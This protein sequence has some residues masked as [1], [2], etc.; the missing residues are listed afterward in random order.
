MTDKLKDVVDAHEQ[1]VNLLELLQVLVSRKMVIIKICAVAIVASVVYSLLLPDIY[2]ATTKVLPPQKDSAGGLSALLSQGGVGSLVSG[3]IGGTSDLYV[4]ILKSRSVSS[5][6]TQ[7]LDLV[8]VYRAASVEEARRTAEGAITAQAGKDG[9]ITITADDTDPKLAAKLANAFADELGRATVR[10]NLSKAG[11]ERLFLEKRLELVKS[12][13][14]AAE[15]DLKAF[16]QKN[17]IMQVDAQVGA[18]LNAVSRLKEELSA[19]EVE[20]SILRNQQTDQSPNVKALNSAIARLK[21]QIHELTG[22][23]SGGEGIPSVGSI[24]GMG[25]EYSRKLRELKTQEAV[26]EQLTKQYE[27]AKLSEA[28]DSSSLQVLDEAVV[29][30]EKS[31]PKRSKLVIAA[32]V[33]AFIFSVVVVFALEYLSRTSIEDR[34][35]IESIKRDVFTLRRRDNQQCDQ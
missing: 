19:K 26:F 7:R 29:P 11:A 30:L 15:D 34:K 35:I 25:L 8:T 5:A 32:T 33:V 28:K 12:S 24:P 14:K 23:G 4:A 3:G 2:S 18:S 1:E 6:V 9:I 20:L 31:K 13:L 10:L 21:M 16:S 27:V 22:T 17:S